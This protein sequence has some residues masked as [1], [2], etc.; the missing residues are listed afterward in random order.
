MRSLVSHR[1][2]PWQHGPVH[3]QE[4]CGLTLTT[5]SAKWLGGGAGAERGLCSGHRDSEGQ[6]VMGHR[7]AGRAKPTENHV[8]GE[9]WAG[10]ARPH[11]ASLPSWAD[12]TGGVHT[13]P[14]LQVSPSDS[15]NSAENS[16]T[17]RGTDSHRAVTSSLCRQRPIAGT[18]ELAWEPP[19]WRCHGLAHAG[20]PGRASRRGRFQVPLDPLPMACTGFLF[21]REPGTS[22]LGFSSVFF[23]TCVLLCR[24]AGLLP[25]PWA[26]SLS[27]T[28]REACLTDRL[29]ASEAWGSK[30]LASLRWY[31]QSPE[32]TG[33]AAR[34]PWDA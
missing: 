33:C 3:L 13:T 10:E 7:E 25:W 19:P 6:W 9:P 2:V 29:P 23:L 14:G 26:T 11:C 15:M 24:Q 27:S 18:R 17:Q 28:A 32:G 12:S 31:V 34:S 22:C 20:T 30:L 5:V 8:Q 16:T 21:H 4:R 1:D